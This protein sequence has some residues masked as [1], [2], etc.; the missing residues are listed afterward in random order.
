MVVRRPLRT[1]PPD[2]I[3]AI[4]A[5][6]NIVHQPRTLLVRGLNA[7]MGTAAGADELVEIPTDA[8]R[9]TGT[10]PSRERE[11]FIDNLL[12][13]IHSIIVMIKWTGLA[14]WE[15]EFPFPG[16]LTSTFLLHR[17]TSPRGAGGLWV[18]TNSHSTKV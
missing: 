8:H 16:S 4:A 15:F 3:G 14:P 6:M 10:K 1:H 5:L 13:R 18:G 12:V 7:G 9:P 17:N 2:P 11:F